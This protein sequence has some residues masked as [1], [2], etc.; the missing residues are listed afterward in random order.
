MIVIAIGNE[1]DHLKER[2]GEY[3]E[4]EMVYKL[5][6]NIIKK[7]ISNIFE[8]NDKAHPASLDSIYP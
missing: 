4:K 7:I 3:L 2:N 8:Y 6:N 1:A 5:K